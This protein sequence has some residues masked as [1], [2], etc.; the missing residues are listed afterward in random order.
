MMDGQ[1]VLCFDCGTKNRLRPGAS[2]VPKCGSCGAALPVRAASGRFARRTTQKHDRPQHAQDPNTATSTGGG[3]SR[4]FVGFFTFAV[5]IGLF[6]V[7]MAPAAQK[8]LGRATVTESAAAPQTSPEPPTQSSKPAQKKT[9]PIAKAVYQQPG[10]MFNRTGRSPVAPFEIVTSPDVDYFV[11]LVDARTG[12]DAVGIYVNGGRTI[13]VPVPLGSYEMRY[14]AGK[15]WYGSK[16]LFGTETNY[17]KADSRFDFRMEN[18]GYSGYTVELILQTNG[19]LRTS[20]IK[21]EQF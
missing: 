4:S 18:G 3:D 17:A 20:T 9:Q 14:A 1:I 7:P 2:G 12:A 13:K 19:N 8:W 15:T 16:A 11:K 10:I 6:L 21:A 5:L